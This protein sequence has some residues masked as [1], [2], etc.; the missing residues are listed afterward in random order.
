MTGRLLHLSL[1][2]CI[3]RL[4]RPHL[5]ESDKILSAADKAV[6][7]LAREKLDSGAARRISTVGERSSAN[8]EEEGGRG[9]VSEAEAVARMLQR[10]DS[11]PGAT[12]RDQEVIR[13]VR[14]GP[15]DVAALC[16]R[17]NLLLDVVGREC[18]YRQTA[19]TIEHPN[20]PHRSMLANLNAETRWRH[21]L[22]RAMGFKVMAELL[23]KPL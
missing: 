15:F 8:L 16:V 5:Y 7:E 17:E 21:R 9:E 10:V 20:A 6:F 23:C 14:A 3:I 13:N 22:L 19:I 12:R 2:E 4:L 1:L 11:A 18:L